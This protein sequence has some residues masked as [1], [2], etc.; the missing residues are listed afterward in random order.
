GAEGDRERGEPR[1]LGAVRA[2]ERAAGLGDRRLRRLDAGLS[3]VDA[4]DN[5]RPTEMVMYLQGRTATL[6]RDSSGR[7]KADVRTH[8]LPRVLMEPLV[9]QP[10]LDRAFGSSRLPRPVMTLADAARRP[11]GRS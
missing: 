10:R 5:G 7:W 4:D 3:V 11:L 8:N 1:G 2:A 9:Y 6:T